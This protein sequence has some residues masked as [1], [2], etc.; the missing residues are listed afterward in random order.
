M[1]EVDLEYKGIDGRKFNMAWFIVAG[2]FIDFLSMCSCSIC[3][4]KEI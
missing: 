4:V 2:K 3:I 1:E